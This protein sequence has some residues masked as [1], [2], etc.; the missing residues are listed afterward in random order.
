MLREIVFIVHFLEVTIGLYEINVYCRITF[1]PKSL[2]YAQ[3]DR[4]IWTLHIENFSEI[5]FK[6]GNTQQ[7]SI[8]IF[9]FSAKLIP[10]TK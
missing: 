8:F 9:L 3:A 6:L 10:K 1:L 2:L 5:H 7:K 4:R